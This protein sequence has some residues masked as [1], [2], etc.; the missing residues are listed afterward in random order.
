M[1]KIITNVSVAGIFSAPSFQSEMITQ[2]LFWEELEVLEKKENWYKVKLFDNYNGWI[3]K[4]YTIKKQLFEKHGA[5]IETNP[6]GEIKTSPKIDSKPILNCTFGVTIPAIETVKINELWWHKI[7]L[8]NLNIGWIQDFGFDKK[9][10]IRKTIEFVSKKLL[11]TPYV[12]GGR[13]S[14]GFDCSGFVQTIFKFCGIYLPRDSKDQFIFEKLKPIEN[15]MNEV[16]DLVFFSK[17]DNINHIGIS[18]GKETFIHSSGWVK[19]N[20][21]NYLDSNYDD[22]LAKLHHST[23]SIQKLV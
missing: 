13:S 2:S 8:P 21:L 3:N 22:N 1:K 7:L 9:L 20:S 4:F 18:L 16:G 10:S 12:W 6:I 5:Y 11:G 15:K 23:L 14:F 19:V 17:N